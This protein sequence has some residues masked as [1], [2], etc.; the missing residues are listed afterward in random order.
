MGDQPKTDLHGDPVRTSGGDE[1]R[2]GPVK[3]DT[4]AD[5]WGQQVPVNKD[6]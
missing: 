6:D 4:T 3:G 1:I 5:G 2:T